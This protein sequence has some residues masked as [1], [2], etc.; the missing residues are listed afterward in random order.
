MFS[1]EESKRLRQDFWIAF[2]KSYPQKWILYNTKVKGLAF[3]FHFDTKKAMVSVDVEHTD[4]E[5]RIKLWEKL[6]S[7]KS[8]LLEDYLLELSFEDS[9][10]LDNQKEISR[11][12]I[13]KK[14]VSIYN[15]NSWQE[16]MIFF[17]SNMLQFEAFFIEF[18]DIISA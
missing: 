4:L 16:T 12:Y 10:I 8:I 17:H 13:E 3:K 11:I 14:G 9:Y 1:K 7:L 18:R 15:K 2:G 5:K 6:T